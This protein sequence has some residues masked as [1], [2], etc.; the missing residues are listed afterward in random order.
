MNERTSNG[1]LPIEVVNKPGA[2][3]PAAGALLGT[4]LF[5]GASGMAAAQTSGAGGAGWQ[6]EVTP[7]LWMSGLKGDTPLGNL[8]KTHV[9][10]AFGDLVDALDFAIAGAFEARN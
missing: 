5:I 3:H 4:A 8:P 6:Y 7:Y 1:H 2:R 9:D 10:V